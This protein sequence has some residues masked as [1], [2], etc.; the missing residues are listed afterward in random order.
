MAKAKSPVPQG[1]HTVTPHLILDDAA[2]AIDWYKRG[3]GADEISRSAGPDGKIMHAEIRIGNSHLYLNDA[4]GGGK[5]PKALGG[6]PI[7]L[8]LYVDD[9][10][11]LF[12]RAVS[13]GATVAPGPMGQM[14]DQF[15]GDRCGTLIDPA[16]FQWTIATRKEDLTPD[17]LNR[18]ADEFFKQF[19]SMAKE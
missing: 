11:A 8:W 3:F 13:A 7:G 2:T 6:S 9:A 17:E 5:G 14:Q 16:G 15:W 12:N 4:M 19:A 18:R 10:D 1:L